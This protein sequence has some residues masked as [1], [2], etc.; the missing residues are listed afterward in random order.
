MSKRLRPMGLFILVLL[1]ALDSAWA[2][3]GVPLFLPFQGRATDS[4]GQPINTAATFKFRVYP[5][6]GACYIYE[7]TQVI[8]PNG[9][10]FFSVILGTLGNRTGPANALTTVFSNEAAM[11]DS[12]AATYTPSANDWRRLEVL[13]DGVAMPTMQTIAASAFSINSQM[14]DGKTSADYIQ[15]AGNV[16][17]TNMNTLTGSVDASALHH[18]DGRYVTL[19]GNNSISGNLTSSGS[20]YAVGAGSKIGIG[21]AAPTADF[22]IR[23]DSPT[24]LL[25]ANSGMGGTPM[26]TFSSGANQRA[27]IRSSET[28][29]ELRFYTGTTEAMR[30]DASQNLILAGSLDVAG[31]VG[32]GQYTNATE[33]TLITTLSGLGA[34][35]IGTMWMNTST[36]T[37]KVWDGTTAIGLGAGSYVSTVSAGTGLTNSGTATAVTLNVSYGTAAGTAVQG[38][39][40]FGGDVSGTY[41]SLTV[42][43][44][45]GRDIDNTAPTVGQVLTWNNTTSRWT[46]QTIADSQLSG[47]VAL[48]NA[49]N[50]FTN[51][52]TIQVATAS[53]AA[54][55]LQSTDNST[56][57]NLLALV[58]SGGATVASVR[59]DGIPTATTDLTTKSYVDTGLGTK[60]N[61]SGGTM[62]GSIN[63]G[64]NSITNMANPSGNQ[65][66]A[67]KIYVDTTLATR[68]LASVAPSANQVLMWNGSQWQPSTSLVTS[69]A[70]RGGD[71]VLTYNDITN[72]AGVYLT[73]QPGSSACNPNEVLKW[74]GSAWLCGTDNNAGGDITDVNPGTGLTG[75]GTSGNVTL[76]LANTAVA[77]GSYGSASQVSTFTVDQQGRLTAA[78][79][80]PIAIN[81]TSLNQSG[82][83]T[84]QTLQWNGSFWLPVTDGGGTVTLL[85]TNASTGLLG[86]P[87]STTGTFSIDVGSTANKIVQLDGSARLPIVDGSLLFNVNAARIGT[88][89]IATSAPTSNQILKW[90]GSQWEPADLSGLGITTVGA[91][92]GLTG[93]GSS[94]GVTLNLADTAVTPGVYGSA[95]QVT[96]F[97][98]DQQGRITGAANV[99]I[100][101]NTTQLNQ[102]SA[103]SGQILKWNGSFW[104]PATDLDTGITALSGDVVATGPGS[105]AATIQANAVT[106]SKIINDA[107]TSAKLNSLGVAINRL[108]ITDGSTGTNVTYANA[109]TDGEVLK[110]NSSTGW[111]CANDVGAG[112]IVTS[113]GTGTG[114]TGGPIT[115]SGTISLANTAV[116]AGTYGSSTSVST[117]TVDAQGRLTGAG[118]VAIAIPTTQLTQTGALTNQVLQWNGAAWVPSTDGGGTVT[119]IA[120]SAATGLLGGP[121]SGT[122]TLSIDVG[123]TANKIVQLDG[124]ARLPIVDGSLLFNLNAERIGTRN[125]GTALPSTNQVLKWNGSQ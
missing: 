114:L 119:L 6:A 14:L 11:P 89:T 96:T 29:N 57:N 9:Y 70:G 100:A 71:V 22:E 32:L 39:A 109:C 115:S 123:S 2:G 38:N 56:T 37:M 50:V 102:T 42:A 108:L 111:G 120:T 75:G 112:G 76:S 91:G 77:A 27:Q 92:T 107:V 4:A 48:K 69:V 34:S 12:C 7:D 8:T 58:G 86:G 105:V 81:T 19:A 98:V 5:P 117:F 121:V 24:I 33:A 122:G 88:R 63:M 28:T 17:Q 84:G 93:G 20:I 21:T 47:N 30:L 49:A 16:T 41:N 23:R 10:G 124:S 74:N 1:M 36:N 72:G 95:S 40:S 83:V 90:N 18:H 78:G 51:A 64:T 73:Y 85:A 26:I 15:V 97:N 54:L 45:Q 65:D 82:A 46:A 103:A 35:A 101:I 13:V 118:S 66:A 116:A 44:I 67:T 25:G 80:I 94:G 99:A 125:V 3:N 68:A 60:L 43:K 61:L 62:S 52:N 87:V 59:A 113:V 104:L 31:T 53:S 79:V 110:W 106:T 55:T